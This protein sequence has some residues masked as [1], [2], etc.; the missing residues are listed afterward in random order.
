MEHFGHD[1]RKISFEKHSIKVDKSSWQRS[2]YYSMGRSVAKLDSWRPYPSRRYFDVRRP[3]KPSTVTNPNEIGELPYDD[4]DMFRKP[5]AVSEDMTGRLSPYDWAK[6][7]E[8]PV[9]KGEP[10][11]GNNDRLDR[12]SPHSFTP[13]KNRER[14]PSLRSPK[15]KKARLDVASKDGK[16][17][18]P[19]NALKTAAP[20]TPPTAKTSDLA[21]ISVANE[22]A[23]KEGK[24]L[25][26]LDGEDQADPRAVRLFR[27]L[28]LQYDKMEGEA[29]A[30]ITQGTQD[31]TQVQ[32]SVLAA[33]ATAT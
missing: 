5:E 33:P 14:S 23:P 19:T 1:E 10:A 9:I 2:D 27:S 16:G 26:D 3:R 18:L 28:A 6:L 12:L 25:F 22:E 30:P 11:T 24:Y 4:G 15:S 32:G 13:H 20:G 8:D 17:G 21:I 7:D 31:V 29:A